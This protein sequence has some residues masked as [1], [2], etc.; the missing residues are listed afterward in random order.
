MHSGESSSPASRPPGRPAESGWWTI[1][2]GLTLVRL[3][4][5]PALVVA[6]ARQ[7]SVP[8]LIIFVTAIISDLADGRIARLR[9]EA[10]PFGGFFDHLTD[11]LFVAAGLFV[12]SRQAVVPV[13]L[14]VLLLLAFAQYT[15]DSRALTGRPLR[16]SR[17]GRWN[18]VAYFV[19][20]GTPVVREGLGLGF[21]SDSWVYWLGVALVGTTLLSMADRLIA[22]VRR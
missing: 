9:G 10:T 20:L 1:A 21:P 19:V 17:I 13:A 11:A 3:L 16:T 18:G 15:F 5:V 14:P 12:L 6:I 7:R 22:L 4:L 2:N 8:A